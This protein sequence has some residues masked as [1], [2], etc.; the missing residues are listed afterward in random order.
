MRPT[1]ILRT[2]DNMQKAEDK[3]NETQVQIYMV[4]DEQPPA[5][6]RTV[7]IK[8]MAAGDTVAV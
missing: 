2:L 4:M 3:M 6:E 5:E 7:M 8:N 1:E